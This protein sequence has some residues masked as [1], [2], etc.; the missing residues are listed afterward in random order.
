MVRAV[1]QALLWKG[2]REM[3]VSNLS[4]SVN[5]RVR[6]ASAEDPYR[7]LQ[8]QFESLFEPLLDSHGIVL[9][10]PSGVG[11]TVIGDN[12]SVDHRGSLSKSRKNGSQMATKIHGISSSGRC[13]GR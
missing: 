7:L 3:E 5:S 12:Q 10:L 13:C 4:T 2:V 6:T 1:D 9:T 11:C 8:N